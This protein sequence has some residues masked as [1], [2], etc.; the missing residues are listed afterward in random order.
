MFV[1]GKS[2]FWTHRSLSEH[3]DCNMNLSGLIFKVY[4]NFCRLRYLGRE[5]CNPSNFQGSDLIQNELHLTEFNTDSS[6]SPSRR[7]LQSLHTAACFIKHR[8]K[9][10]G[11]HKAY[12]TFGG[13]FGGAKLAK[14]VA[15]ATQFLSKFLSKLQILS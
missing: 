2:N 8:R 10:L 7:G 15:I 9:I 11:K 1:T 6:F 3:G 13:F 5:P 12:L 4:R 14:F